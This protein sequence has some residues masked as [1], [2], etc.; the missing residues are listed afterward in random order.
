MSQSNP[1]SE[2]GG[3]KA[4][5]TFSRGMNK[6]AHPSNI[7]AGYYNEAWNAVNQTDK[8]SLT[9]LNN[10]EGFD[11]FST[12]RQFYFLRG[13]ADEMYIQAMFTNG[14]KIVI[15]SIRSAN[16]IDTDASIIGYIDTSTALGN[17]VEVIDDTDPTKNLGSERFNFTF[18]NRIKATFKVNFQEET[19]V[20]FTDGN[21]SPKR[22]NLD[23]T[24][25]QFL[26]LAQETN[27]FGTFNSAHVEYVETLEGGN[28]KPGLYH[29]TTRYLTK[30]TLDTTDFGFISQGVPVVDEFKDSISNEKYDGADFEAPAGSKSIK[31]SVYNIDND[32]D[33]I[34]FFVIAYSGPT[35]TPRAYRIGRKK[36]TGSTSDFVFDGRFEEEVSINNIVNERI[37]Y[38]TAKNIETKDNILFLANLSNKNNINL[39]P[40]ANKLRVQYEIEEH[41]YTER[42]QDSPSEVRGVNPGDFPD[43]Y[44]KEE[45]TFNKKGY[46]RDEVISLAIVGLL[47]DGG[48]T[49][50]FHIPGYID[51]SATSN[52]AQPGEYRNAGSFVHCFISEEKYDN[53]AYEDFHGNSLNGKY[54][55][56]HLMPLHSDE[57]IAESVNISTN[58]TATR[59]W[60]EDT[61]RIL[62]LKIIGLQDALNSNTNLKDQLE[63]IVIVRERRDSFSKRRIYSLGMANRFGLW[64]GL[65]GRDDQTESSHIEIAMMNPLFGDTV[66]ERWDNRIENNSGG[67][68]A[69]YLNGM[70]YRPDGS[71]ELL[72]TC[73]FFSPET[74]LLNEFNFPTS[75][76]LIP[77]Y[78]VE[79]NLNH[80]AS[81]FT[82][83]NAPGYSGPEESYPLVDKNISGQRFTP[84]IR[85]GTN[86][87]DNSG[88][89]F[90]I[91]NT[92]FQRRF[93]FGHYDDEDSDVGKARRGFIYWLFGCFY[94]EIETLSNGN[95]DYDPNYAQSI[96]TNSG[97][98]IQTTYKV[99]W[100]N[101][102]IVP[103]SWAHIINTQNILENC[104]VLAKETYYIT[105]YGGEDLF[106]IECNDKIPVPWSNASNIVQDGI[107][108]PYGV[109]TSIFNK[110]YNGK[111]YYSIRIAIEVD[112]DQ[113]NG[114]DFFVFGKEPNSNADPTNYGIV[115]RYVY[116]IK[117]LVKNQYKTLDGNEYIPVKV[118]LGN[119]METN[120]TPVFFN[121]D[122]FIGKF[123]YQ[124]SQSI[125]YAADRGDN[126]GRVNGPVP[127]GFFE[128]H[129]GLL[130]AG[131]YYFTESEVNVEYRHFPVQRNDRGN[132]EKFGVPYVPKESVINCLKAD[133]ELGQ[134][135]GYNIEYSKENE[136]KKY[137][138]RPFGFEEVLRF[139][140]RVIHS[141]QSFEGEQSDVWRIFRAN[142][143]HDV[144][145]NKGEITNI[146]DHNGKFY[147]HTTDSLFMS[148]VNEVVQATT[149]SAS[150]VFLGNSGVF[151]RPSKEIFPQEGGYAGCLHDL[152]ATVTPF[153]FV[154]V[155][156][157][158]K[159]VFMLGEQL[160]E[161]SNKG[162]SKWF[163]DNLINAKEN[164]INNPNGRGLS[165]FYDGRNQRLILSLKTLTDNSFSISYSLLNQAWFSFHNYCIEV[166]C[167]QDLDIYSASNTENNGELFINR[168]FVNGR[169]GV[170]YDQETIH[171]FKIRVTHNL[172]SATDKVYDNWEILG[173]FIDEQNNV[174]LRDEFFDT[175]KAWTETKYTGEIPFVLKNRNPF[176]ENVKRYNSQW[177]ACVPLS[178]TVDETVNRFDP[179]NIDI[180]MKNKPR[181]RG[182]YLVSEF[183]YNNDLNYRLTLQ[184]ILTILRKSY[185]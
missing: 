117:N 118:F 54:I 113:D 11:Q 185:R 94:D 43:N 135:D 126:W 21:E 151:P 141:D 45:Y 167:H 51:D 30:E 12:Y 68:S 82:S 122:V 108:N 102:G 144:P 83:M 64:D 32:F 62:G 91:T 147:I 13:Y 129:G 181:M 179:V 120:E 166:G 100:N 36:I 124:N 138:V 29:F 33:Y 56:H 172:D 98:R 28:V 153:G 8:G 63:G 34:E 101:I 23:L 27:L 158:N 164:N 142:S 95:T 99:P 81:T 38:D 74:I 134:S 159:K 160:T 73:G 55:R 87:G 75:S 127:P 59:A 150:D 175:V 39:Q 182:K 85:I 92:D 132:I 77:V 109:K 4:Q 86:P 125:P 168:N 136:I 139:P 3:A 145:K 96:L 148:F 22:I 20:Y 61:I 112:K 79:A 84:G 67:S 31:M 137:F 115:E 9:L 131:N 146:F 169:Y 46:A 47:K 116:Q 48:K 104:K 152:A 65:H 17:Y 162:M 140:N 171:P 156:Y 103:E 66:L 107:N 128:R 90:V 133:A 19:V 18:E 40:I 163:Q 89:P 44:K 93:T 178:A 50:A 161:I 60:T 78:R 105:N 174:Y 42:Q 183:K 71:D 16:G 180:N 155:D 184:A 165:L 123:Y 121:G 154:F 26:N 177:Q 52:N 24:S 97:V 170:Y 76:R 41:T 35:S 149:D 5:N 6:D 15:F 72:A 70:M 14:D 111:D 106:V 37:N 58:T 157:K 114:N 110:T 69:R 130:K 7:P 1:Q 119:E 25:N 2:Q 176:K 88:R 49:E 53:D 10:E 80:T 173:E 143:F 57:P